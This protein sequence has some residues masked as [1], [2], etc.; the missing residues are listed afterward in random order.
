M[1]SVNE[2]I[3]SKEVVATSSEG[4]EQLGYIFWYSVTSNVEVTRIEL[5][6]QFQ[7]IGIDENWL[8]NPIRSSDAFRRATKE[9]QRKKVPTSDPNMFQNFL[10]REVY[11][12]NKLIQRNIVIETV[13]HNGKRLDYDSNA[14]VMQLNKED[15]SF[16]I[17]SSN[18]TASELAEQAKQRFQKYIDYYSAQQLRVMINKY[19]SS[20]APTPVRSNGGVYFIPQS[21]S[22][23]LKKLQLLCEYLQSEGVS[24]PLQDTSENKNL[25]LSKL[26][27]EMKEVLNRCKELSDQENLKKQIYKDSIEEARRVAN[28]YK[29]YKETLTI[30]VNNLE[31]MLNDL[32][33]SAVELT[34]KITK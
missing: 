11:S 32:R 29:A 22:K 7:T 3:K 9:V 23:D 5:E 6:Q 33:I 18:N 17:Q 25:V 8:P 21:F 28:T 12:D 31:E 14:T 27:N 16:S 13:D 26:E 20:L 10:V 24:V 1:A 4:I 30:D 19:L 2:K 15:N 34:Q